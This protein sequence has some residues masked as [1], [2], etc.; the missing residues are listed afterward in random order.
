M[1]GTG[2]KSIG[3]DYLIRKDNCYLCCTGGMLRLTDI[4]LLYKVSWLESGKI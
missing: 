4:K 3:M 2:V 1:L